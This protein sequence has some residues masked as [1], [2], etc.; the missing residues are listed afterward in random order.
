[1]PPAPTVWL[2]QPELPAVGETQQSGRALFEV[3]DLAAERVRVAVTGDVDA[4]NRQALG[5][6]V[7]RHIR[8]S[9]QLI[10]DLSKVDF[11]GSQ[12]FTALHYVSVHCARRDVDWMIVG[13]RAVDR[14]LRICDSE[15]ELPV[16]HD[17]GVAVDRLDRCAR[18]QHSPSWAGD[19]QAVTRSAFPR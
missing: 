4:T 2:Y 17:L 10:V 6:F 1:M 14:I 18:Y 3:H 5:H 12:G 9:Q 15:A 19:C 7:E 11:F 16:V 13:N 8:I